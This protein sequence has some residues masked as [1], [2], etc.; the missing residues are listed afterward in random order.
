M[1]YKLAV[2]GSPVSHS[3]SP[4][5]HQQFAAQFGLDIDY[6]K[7]EATSESFVK[8]IQQFKNS[9]AI[10]A[11]VTAPFKIEAYHLANEV[12]NRA[13]IAGAANT[14]LFRQD[15]PIFADN[16]DGLG[17]IRDITQNL[18]YSLA[19]KRILILGSGGATRSILSALLQ[20]QPKE[21]ILIDKVT[22]QALDVAEALHSTAKQYDVPLIVHSYPNSH[23]TVFDVVF[24]ATSAWHNLPIMPATLNFSS[25]SMAY[26]LKYASCDTIFI[27]WAKQQNATI[28]KDGIGMLIEQAAVGFEIW[29]GYQPDTKSVIQAAKTI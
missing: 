6:Q 20:Q 28:T 13:K 27:S 17:F 18:Q 15:G 14:L 21:I 4:W 3:R 29:T 2:F 23:D 22:K 7:I 16:T 19:Q 5:I 26:D 12:S 8:L 25:N 24:D 11:N 10:G 1:K 9:G